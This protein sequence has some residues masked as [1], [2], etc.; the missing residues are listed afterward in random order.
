MRSSST[1]T[2]TPCSSDFL[3]GGG[4]GGSGVVSVGGGVGV[5]FRVATLEK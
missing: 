1:V 4:G 3:G 5:V 2:L